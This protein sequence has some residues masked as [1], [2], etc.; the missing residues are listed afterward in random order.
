MPSTAVLFLVAVLQVSGDSDEGRPDPRADTA[1]PATEKPGGTAYD[2]SARQLDISSPLTGDARI[3]ID[4]RLD[5]PAWA[6]GAL[7]TGFTQYDPVEGVPGTQVTD[8]RVLV[9]DD[10]IL[11]GVRALDDDP[12][13]VRA[14]LA[15]R[16]GFGRSDDYVRFVLD[17]FNDGRRA[18]VFQVNPLGVQ[19]DGLWVEGSDRRGDPID[20][21]PDFLWESAG[22]VDAVGY[23]AEVRIPLKSLRFPDVSMQD[24]GIQVVRQIQRNGYGESWAP[25]TGEVANKLSQSGRLRGLEGLDPG[26]FLEFNPVV[27]ATRQ[28]AWDSEREALARDPATGDF[29][30]NMRYGV[31][32]NLTLDATY[33][34]DFSQV[35]ADAGQ[36]AVNERFA[37]FFPEKRPFF[38]EGTDIF[39]M[40]QQLVYTRS[41]GNPVGA[42]KLSGKVGSFNVAYVGAVDEVGGEAEHPVVNLLRLKRDVGGSSSVGMVYTDRTLSGAEFNRVFGADGRFVLG[43]RYTLD[44]LAA[45]SADAQ[46]AGDTEWGSLFSA[47]FRRASR[48]FTL[49]GSFEDVG[50]DF[51][52]RSGFI[53]R[54]GTTQL[55]ARAGYTFR[56]AQGAL[57]ES[58]GPSVEVQGFWDR[59]DFW[60]A[61]GPEES[62]VQLN[63]SAFF[64]NNI[65]GFLSYSRSSFGF[66]SEEYDGLYV[67]EVTGAE[68]S[69]FLPA[70]KF[71]EGLDAVRLRG[72]LRSWERVR[73]SFGGGWS[74]TPIF[75]SGVPADVADR[76]S[77]DVGLTLFPTGSLSAELG[78]RHVSLLRQRDGSQYSSATIPRVQTRYQFTRALFFRAIGEYSSQERGDLLDP[79][80]GA[81]ISYCDGTD[82][83]CS[84]RAGSDSHDFRVEGLLGYEPSPGTVV[85]VGYSRQMRDTSA[86][87][88]REVST[89]AEGLFVKLSYR[90][91][92]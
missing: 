80:T 27:T 16:D 89:R 90:F 38:L 69:P 8:V 2:G 78:L 25:M 22:Q 46:T 1:P 31:T 14:T 48:S 60:A 82:G 77:A 63:L 52:A 84:I 91:R 70:S 3:K 66:G 45:G 62:E 20:W 87:E 67:G 81:P 53:R 6:E 85:F 32:S 74:E 41:I 4:G 30:M 5:E 61:R 43:Q 42:A 19:G 47:R 79:A 39:S 64:R 40:P 18:Y 75:S 56:G 50:E 92:M 83:S 51:R 86:F 12:G 36:I 17:T 7:L 44:V 57:V 88:F 68:G 37:L 24:W 28:G 35:E 23:T 59:S 29:G 13:G 49:N 71:F 21:N 54:V 11:F 55:Q 72:W 58:W 26:R 15:K 34:P 76:W 9:S 65:G 10:A 73:A 33:N